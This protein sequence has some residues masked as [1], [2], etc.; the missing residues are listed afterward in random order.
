MIWLFHFQKIPKYEEKILDR[1]LAKITFLFNI[2][3]LRYRW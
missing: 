2:R 1:I 3:S